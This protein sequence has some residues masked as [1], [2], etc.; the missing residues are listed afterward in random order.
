MP[1]SRSLIALLIGTVAFFALWLV[2]FKGSGSSSSKG[3]SSSQSLGQYQSDLNAAHKAVATSNASNAASG[4][5]GT[6]SSSTATTSKS[7]STTA[8][9]KSASAKS[10]AKSAAKA[11]PVPHLTA[12]VGAHNHATL[13]RLSTVQNA[14]SAHKM[15]VMLFY[16]PSSA[17]DVAVK[18]GLSGLSTHHGR[19]VKV[20]IPL[21]EASNF[22]PVTQQVPVNISPT[23][24]LIAPSGDTEEIVGYSD[25]FEIAQRVDDGLASR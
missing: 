5:D 16:N 1:A 15:V 18:Q 11:K 23:L 17:D 4:N 14:L 12:K 24:V 20:I 2:A 25:P 3:G 7:A 6:S 21:N 9:T 10:P 13:V 8:T 22:T 19:V